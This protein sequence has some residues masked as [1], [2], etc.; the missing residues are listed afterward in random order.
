MA[1]K[2]EPI[3]LELAPLPREQVGP[4]LLLGLD[5]AA[6]AEQVEAH[7]AQRLIG[8]RKNQIGVALEEINWAREV[9]R[10]PDRRALADATSLNTDT[11]DG[12]LRRLEAAYPTG[13]RWQP[14]DMEKSLDDYA[15]AVDVPDVEEVRQAITVPEVPRDVPAVAYLLDQFLRE[16][17]DPWALELPLNPNPDEAA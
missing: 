15:P 4:F 3:V 17:L 2:Q 1:N 6:G 14:L 5:K 8:A 10:D 12:T 9:L 16:P 13:P 11:T 7:W